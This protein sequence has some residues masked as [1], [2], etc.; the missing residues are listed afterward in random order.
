MGPGWKPD[1]WEN[2]G[3]HWRVYF[4]PLSL[5]E[6]GHGSIDDTLQYNTLLSDDPREH[7]SGA[8]RW[9]VGA[10]SPSPEAAVVAQL[11]AAK[12]S[13]AQTA[14]CVRLCEAAKAARRARKVAR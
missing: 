7:N 8:M 5:H 4:G 13:L 11:K 3:W 6:Y 2:L 1:V 14:E 12:K 9:Y 10:L